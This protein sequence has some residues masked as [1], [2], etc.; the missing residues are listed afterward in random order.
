MCRLFAATPSDVTHQRQRAEHSYAQAHQNPAATDCSTDIPSLHRFPQN[1][2]QSFAIGMLYS[3][4]TQNSQCYE[5]R[6]GPQENKRTQCY[7]P[8][9]EEPQM[10]KLLHDLAR[11]NRKPIAILLGAGASATFGYPVTRQLMLN[12][13]RRLQS[14]K[15]GDRKALYDFLCEL[16]PGERLSKERMP[17]VT[18]VLSLLDHALSTGQS[19]LP[20]RTMEQT[21]HVRQLLEQELVESIPDWEDFGPEEESSFDNYCGWLSRLL[22]TRPTGGMALITTNY[23]M[24]A[25]LAALTV[26]GVKGGYGNWNIKDMGKLVDFGFRWVLPDRNKEIQVQ[27]PVRPRISLLKLH[28]STNWLRCP[29]CENIY[30]HPNAPIASVAF[31]RKTTPANTCHCSATRLEPQIVSPSFVRQMRDPNLIAVWKD[32]LDFLRKSDHWVMIGY[33]F[34]D[35]DVAVRALFARAF[36]SRDEQPHISVVQL[37]KAAEV[38]Y[39][40]FFKNESFTYLTGGLNL[41]LSRWEKINALRRRR[42]PRAR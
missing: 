38:N 26:A 15:N 19:L 28:G 2:E 3:A 18:G 31:V 20:K 17:L 24:I 34:P 5:N 21:R 9:N 39:E 36:S 40:S 41:L 7:S 10:D 42:R 33:G 1:I 23:D 22:E 29:L 12:I 8:T 37:D 30:V 13:F 35:E 16:L 25:D 11:S 27:R 6:P 4:G 14:S 32:A